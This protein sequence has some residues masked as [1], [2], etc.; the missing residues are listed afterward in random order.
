MTAPHEITFLLDVDDT[1]LDNDWIERDL[2]RHLDDSFGV[3]RS[4]LYWDLFEKLRTE[5]GYA[6]YLGALQQ[7]RIEYPR[8]PHLLEISLFLVDYP[9][10]DRLYPGALDVIAR[11][12]SWGPTV[13]VSDG[14][15]VFQPRKVERS[16]LWQ[17]VAGHVLIYIH[18]EQMLD[19]VEQRYPAQHYVMVDD[20]LRILA[21]MKNIW[22]D[23]LTTVFPRQGHYA[24]DPK[25]TASYPAA[26]MCVERIGDLIGWDLDALRGASRPRSGTEESAA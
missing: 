22:G 19:D 4:A 14:D 20:K 13:I 15:V 6:D 24:L 3:E 26:D 5:L 8:D 21:A 16:G 7:Y 23:R 25:N 1:L 10:V 11:L 9:F 12:R 18:K 17:A 2:R